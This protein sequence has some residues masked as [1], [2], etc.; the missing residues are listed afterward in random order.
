M[1]AEQLSLLARSLVGP[2]EVP[3]LRRLRRRP[4]LSRYSLRGATGFGEDARPKC[5]TQ[6]VRVLGH[7]LEEETKRGTAHNHSTRRERPILRKHVTQKRV[8]LASNSCLLLTFRRQ[9]L[10]QWGARRLGDSFPLLPM[11]R[12]GSQHSSPP[13]SAP[14]VPFEKVARTVAYAPRG[15]TQKFWRFC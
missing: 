4:A 8:Q 13:F 2:Y 6:L 12:N 15:E 7:A 5:T 10:W 11:E 14:R 9:T 3:H 1:V